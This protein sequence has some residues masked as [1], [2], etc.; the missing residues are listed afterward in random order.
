VQAQVLY[1]ASALLPP[2][3]EAP[4]GG[5]PAASSPASGAP[6]ASELA[7]RTRFLEESPQLLSKLVGDLLPLVLQVHGSSVMAQVQS[8]ALV[9]ITRALYY[10]PTDMLRHAGDTWGSQPDEDCARAPWLLLRLAAAP[11]KPATVAGWCGDEARVEESG[12]RW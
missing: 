8:Q 4:A 11:I 6:A 3:P 12:V 2:V 10:T 7:A 1:L 5:S 9:I